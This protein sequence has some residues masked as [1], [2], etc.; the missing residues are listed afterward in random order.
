MFSVLQ[1]MINYSAPATEQINTDDFITEAILNSKGFVTQTALNNMGFLTSSYV[2]VAQNTQMS[3]I[4]TSYAANGVPTWS[5]QLNIE[6]LVGA[7]FLIGLFYCTYKA[8][9]KSYSDCK[10]FFTSITS[11]H[12]IDVSLFRSPIDLTVQKVEMS[13][14][15]GS[16][17]NLFL[18]NTTSSGFVSKYSSTIKAANGLDSSSV[19]TLNFRSK[20]FGFK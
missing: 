20:V 2:G 12:C 7:K 11:G 5:G 10:L 18:F 8:N 1:N 6:G 14:G 16:E 4:N 15:K 17:S 13:G 19:P 3:L 9:S